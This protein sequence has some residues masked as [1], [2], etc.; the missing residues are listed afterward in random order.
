MMHTPAG[1]AVFLATLGIALS[2]PAIGN[3]WHLVTPEEEALDKG[4]PH[5]AAPPDSTAPPTIHLVQPDI[6]RPL[7]NPMTIEVQFAAEPGHTIDRASFN[8]TYGWLGINITRRLLEH[9]TWT[10]NGLVAEDI[11]LPRGN[12]RVT[13]SIAD[14]SGRRSSRTF[15]LSVS[16]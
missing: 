15:N 10:P 1:I 12:H 16:R 6:S 7:G 8:A 14:T 13:M 11:E 9:S 2:T 4:T 5:S 3:A